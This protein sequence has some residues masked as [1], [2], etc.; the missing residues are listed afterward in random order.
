M[1]KNM[2]QDETKAEILARIDSLTSEAKNKWG[3]MNVRQGLRHM[4][5]A[6]ANA[7]G[8]HHVVPHKGGAIKKKLMKFFLLNV[9]PP[10]GKAETFPEFNTVNLGIDPPDFEAERTN[11]KAQ[12]EKFV[13]AS[14]L[15]PESA[16]GGPFSR[17]DWGRLMYVHTDH[18][19]REFGA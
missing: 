8:E 9:N 19:L 15:I 12:I 1:Q 16:G 14:N 2:F 11:L 10:K 5:F 13:N 6:F 7:V 4:S 18:H 17:E 3:K